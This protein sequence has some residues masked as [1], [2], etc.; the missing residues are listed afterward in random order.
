MQ[1]TLFHDRM[2]P[3]V[4]ETVKSALVA[5]EEEYLQAHPGD[6]IQRV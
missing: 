6:R 5:L 3:K 2:G 1:G 4:L